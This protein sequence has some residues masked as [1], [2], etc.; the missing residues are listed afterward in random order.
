MHKLAAR[1]AQRVL[2]KIPE[3]CLPMLGEDPNKL[4]Q[5]VF[6]HQRLFYDYLL[7]KLKDREYFRVDYTNITHVDYDSNFTNCDDIS[8][9]ATF[10]DLITITCS[11]LVIVGNDT[12]IHCS[13]YCHMSDDFGSMR[14]LLGMEST[15]VVTNT[16]TFIVGV[17]VLLCGII[18][19]WALMFIFCFSHKTGLCP[20]L[21][22]FRFNVPWIDELE[23]SVSNHNFSYNNYLVRRTVADANPHH[24]GRLR[25]VTRIRLRNLQTVLPYPIFCTQRQFLDIVQRIGLRPLMQID[26]FERISF[27]DLA[28]L[29]N[30]SIH[31]N[32]AAV[33]L[34][35]QLI[36]IA[37]PHFL[38]HLPRHNNDF[39]NHPL[40][41]IDEEVTWFEILFPYV[42]GF[43][44]FVTTVT[45]G[46]F[47]VH[48]IDLFIIYFELLSVTIK[49]MA[50]TFV[51]LY[52]TPYLRFPYPS[53]IFS[54]FA[55]ELLKAYVFD[56]YMHPQ[57]AIGEFF[58]YCY[59]EGTPVKARIRPFLLHMFTYALMIFAPLYF[60]F[61]LCVV[62]HSTF[63]WYQFVW[64]NRRGLAMFDVKIFMQT[65]EDM[66]NHWS[67][68]FHFIH[69]ALRKDFLGISSFFVSSGK[70]KLILDLNITMDDILNLVRLT[71]SKDIE[72]KI[73]M[74]SSDQSKMV[75]TGGKEHH[76]FFKFLI[77]LLPS[78]F[79]ASPTTSSLITLFV[80]IF[81]LSIVPDLGICSYISTFIN[82]DFID[83]EESIFFTLIKC[84]QHIWRGFQL[85]LETGNWRDFFISSTTVQLRTDALDFV[86][87]MID[88]KSP[89]D[90]R[91]LILFGNK[92][93]I[94][95]SNSEHRSSFPL[96]KSVKEKLVYFQNGIL[97]VSERTPPMLVWLMG[98]PGAGKTTI[99]N[100]IVSIVGR[101][102]FNRKLNQS[103][104]L[105]ISSNDKFPIEMNVNAHAK[106]A[107]MND[108][109]GEH[110]QD[111]QKGLVPFDETI[112]SIIDTSSLGFPAAAVEDKGKSFNELKALLVSSNDTGY[113]F[114]NKA[115][116]LER[117]IEDGVAV[118]MSVMED[119]HVLSFEAYKHWSSDKRNDHTYFTFMYPVIA[120]DA[121][122]LNF[123]QNHL[124]K[125]LSLHDFISF[126]FCKFTSHEI[127]QKEELEFRSMHCCPCGVTH[128]F[129]MTNSIWKPFTNL[130]TKPV[131]TPF[132]RTPMCSCGL[133]AGKYNCHI[134]KHCPD[135]KEGYFPPEILIDF[136][137]VEQ[138]LKKKFK[139]VALTGD[140][141]DVCFYM[142]VFYACYQFRRFSMSEWLLD[143]FRKFEIMLESKL[144]K[145]EHI[146]PG[147]LSVW[148]DYEKIKSR[149]G[150]VKMLNWI[151]VNSKAIGF[152]AGITISAGVVAVLFE[153]FFGVVSTGTVIMREDVDPK[154]ML[155]TNHRQV[156]VT[157]LNSNLNENSWLNP[158]VNVQFS[159][160]QTCGVATSDLETMVRSHTL[161]IRVYDD[162]DDR[163]SKE[164]FCFC[165]S[166]MFLLINRHYLDVDG[167]LNDKRVLQIRDIKQ[168]IGESNCKPI[169][170]C[171]LYLV[172]MT[173]Q[174]ISKEMI[175]YFPTTFVAEQ[176]E[177]M[178]VQKL[179][180]SI[181]ANAIQ[182]VVPLPI[183][184][185]HKSF[186]FP[187]SE[188]THGDCGQPVISTLKGGSFI[189]GLISY[190]YATSIFGGR[191]CGGTI[192]TKDMLIEAYKLFP[193][194]IV[195]SITMTQTEVVS[196]IGPPSM[197]SELLKIDSPHIVFLGTIP[198]P[199][200]HF[201]SQYQESILYPLVVDKMTEPYG[202]PRKVMG[203][204]PDNVWKSALTNTFTPMDRSFT[205]RI[206]P[207]RVD[208]VIPNL[209]RHVTSKDKGKTILSPCTLEEAIFGFEDFLIDR[210]NFKTSVGPILATE[211]LR[212]KYDLFEK[213]GKS[214]KESIRIRIDTMIKNYA[215]G[216]CTTPFITGSYKDEIRKKKKLDQ[217]EIR[218]FYAA[219]FIFNIVMRMYIGPI[220]QFLLARPYQ[221]H[222]F[223]G[224]NAASTSWDELAKWLLELDY[225]IDSDFKWFDI[226]MDSELFRIC[227]LIFYLIAK[228]LGY[229]EEAAT[230]VYFLTVSLMVQ[231]M[232]HK[233]DVFVKTKGNPSGVLTTLGLNS[234][235]NLFLM[236][237]AYDKLVTP[238]DTFFKNVHPSTQGDDN[239]SSI[240]KAVI[241]FYNMITIAECYKELG[242]E[243]TPANKSGDVRPFIDFSELQFLKRS[244]VYDTILGYKAPLTPDSMWKAIAFESRDCGI[245]P[246]DR[247]CAVLEQVQREFFLHGQASFDD[248]QSLLD[249]IQER[250][251]LFVRRLDF[252]TLTTQYLENGLAIGTFL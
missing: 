1:I 219:D 177:I 5:L 111:S 222:C 2:E 160:I 188:A 164:I 54:A 206:N 96:L 92:L 82:F 249:V 209:V 183:Y 153:R 247:L 29:M 66:I 212:N 127:H 156:N 246:R 170:G 91:E 94:S 167:K 194:P 227:G 245:S 13:Q 250:H 230:I 17:F 241:M 129:H 228:D 168:H 213:D 10:Q 234:I 49:C 88:S 143:C 56:I 33:P 186:S 37:D 231:V 62:V 100:T 137:V 26:W 197:N 133:V 9:A 41:V 7:R 120:K 141:G 73:S 132:T 117:R 173:Q 148:L 217:F 221:S 152:F 182:E 215:N 109:T 50:W 201:K 46:L 71:P 138:Q 225:F 103:E 146:L 233:N 39:R 239:V 12:Y 57:F 248:F 18:Q 31:S 101:S 42:I 53:I 75:L 200:N 243:V 77:G 107:F 123:Q 116:R 134:H 36:P 208:R 3:K 84:T 70:Y 151:E 220:L 44:S 166:P 27:W 229:T 58:M 139:R 38:Q 80:S 126:L 34:H 78:K 86:N 23:V 210:V 218:V 240:S 180:S 93:V 105:T 51:T 48:N 191:T 22:T 8:D 196:M 238:N 131:D 203:K 223:G 193:D 211:N 192:L 98:D 214:L 69:L 145:T 136:P 237:Y 121:K 216:H 135:T 16:F 175:K 130:C 140:I 236:M 32:L 125:R 251:Q 81:T 72:S 97:A 122:I 202:I 79:R 47:Y 144:I 40:P 150:Y 115:I 162:W 28:I 59:M 25:G 68:A 35:H 178:Y 67:T 108:V 190:M 163:F 14:V 199:Q 169:K 185:D 207:D 161:Q 242:L 158:K 45:F 89:D 124:K 110:S 174:I 99:M 113:S 52:V 118:L 106:V 226:S 24:L 154:S 4:S 235:I 102:I 15:R 114:E 30:F 179:K 252:T 60:N 95:L 165:V 176:F 11:K 171:E 244:F 90:L 184:G 21:A 87:E 55:E 63:N 195:N 64:W 142:I 181:T 61:V 20:S 205:C 155:T 65:H 43:Y 147:M 74:F 172:R 224:R 83:D 19:M 159:D 76:P 149:Y 104:I 6:E 204:N 119:N 85:F 232:I 189:L 128:A 157:S 198:A 187:N 112:R